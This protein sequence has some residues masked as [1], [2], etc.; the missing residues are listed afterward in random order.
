MALPSL[1]VFLLPA[2]RV[3]RKKKTSP[4]QG[5]VDKSW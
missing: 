1:A 4:V 5:L 2:A 3:G